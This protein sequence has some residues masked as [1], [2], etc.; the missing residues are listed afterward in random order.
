MPNPAFKNQGRQTEGGEYEGKVTEETAKALTVSR[1]GGEGQETKGH[2][3][4]LETH[5][6]GIV[7]NTWREVLKE[8][9]ERRKR[10]TREGKTGQDG[11]RAKRG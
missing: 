1:A 6:E 7:K 5:L 9:G 2:R 3:A 8:M 4:C 10:L 11:A